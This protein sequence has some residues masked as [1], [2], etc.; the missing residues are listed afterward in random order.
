MLIVRVG[1][2][3]VSAIYDCSKALIIVAL[4]F[5]TLLIEIVV[6]L[7]CPEWGQCRLTPN[8]VSCFVSPS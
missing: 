7:D 2:C 3:T 1:S 5:V 6:L 8:L 4:L